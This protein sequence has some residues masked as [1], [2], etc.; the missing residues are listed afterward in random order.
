M[1]EEKV[2]LFDYI[3][4]INS[5]NYN[6]SDGS[7]YVPYVVNTAFSYF[8][9]TVFI[10]NEI[11]KFAN[12][13]KKQHYDFLFHMVKKG[14][15]YSK[16]HKKAKSDDIAMISD[17]YNISLVEAETYAVLMTK[18]QLEKMKNMYGGV[19]KNG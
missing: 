19:T 15:R 14:K 11:N 9:D 10:A 4:A 13:D 7:E 2:G 8:P 17:Y 12:V 6:Y 16:W 1:S 18:E 5:K 3:N